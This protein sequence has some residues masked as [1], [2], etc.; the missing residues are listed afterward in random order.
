M[1]QS[2]AN[3]DWQPIETAPK[4]GTPMLLWG[5]DDCNQG[6]KVWLGCWSTGCWYGPA[7]VGYEHRSDTEYLKPTHWMKLPE[8][9]ESTP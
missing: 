7:W 6:P 2:T 3:H 8:P 1:T 5:I 4:D 9:P